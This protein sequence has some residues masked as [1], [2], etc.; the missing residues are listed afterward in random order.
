MNEQRK[1][2]R[3]KGGHIQ[4]MGERKEGLWSTNGWVNGQRKGRREGKVMINEWKGKG[5][6]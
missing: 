4:S 5:G 3:G 2:R 1:G 6:L